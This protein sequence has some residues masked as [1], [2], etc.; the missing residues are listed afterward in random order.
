[1]TAMATSF[2]T[3]PLRPELQT[4]VTRLGFTEMTDIQAKAL[5]VSLDGADIVAHARTGS[6]K[7]AVFGLTL[8]QKLDVSNRTPQAIVLCPTRELAAQLVASIRALAVGLDGVRVLLVTGGKSSRDQR[9]ALQ[10]GAHVVVGTPGRV[11]HQLELR[12]LKTSSLRTVVLDEADRM[13]D[14]GFEDEVLGILSFVPR[15]HQTLLFS[16]TWPPAMK[17]LSGRVQRSPEMIGTAALLDA[18]VLKQHV[19]LCGKGE[20]DLALR[21]LL[22][23]RDPVPTLIFCETRIQCKRVTGVLC[24]LGVAALALHGELEQRDREEVMVCFRNGSARVLVATNV[25]ARGLDVE[26]IELVISY[27]LANDAQVHVH[28]VGRTARAATSGE[29]ISLVIKGS[30]EMSRLAAIETYL[31]TELE[32]VDVPGNA[33]G[34]LERWSAEW[35]TLDLLGGRGD[36]LRPGDLLGALTRGVGLDG[37]D[38]GMIILTDK[39]TWIAVRSGVARKAV[40]GLNKGRIK[41]KRYRVHLVGDPRR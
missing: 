30:K 38:V 37:A 34:S 31:G 4:G 33:D 7:T 15:D 19:V 11:L 36:K 17:E 25:A 39:R 1:M 9:D 6:G 23:S 3:L 18:T 21:R 41:K 2:D 16:A 28:R 12:R 8:L 24:G 22:A 10:A 40:D 29:A 26:G 14:M 32:R 5:P 20:R 13:L 35:R 27:E